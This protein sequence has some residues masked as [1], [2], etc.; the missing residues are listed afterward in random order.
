MN[1]IAFLLFLQLGAQATPAPV[2]EVPKLYTSFWNSDSN[3]QYNNNCYNYSTNRVTNSFAQPGEASGKMYQDIT[4]KDVYEAASQDLGLEPTEYFPYTDKKDD[5]LIAVVVAP[6]YDYHWYRRDD[7]GQWSHKPGGTP[8]TEFDN[9][10][11]II[12]DP[13]TADRGPYKEFCGY[14]RIKNIKGHDHEQDGGQVRV[15]NMESLPEK[16]K[17]TVEILKYSGR[18]NPT[19]DLEE[20]LKDPKFVE[21]LRG[22]KD[23]MVPLAQAT[24]KQLRDMSKLGDR[25][26]LIR[27][28]EGKVFRKGST[29]QITGGQ[30]VLMPPSGL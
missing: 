1:T 9:S 26:F 29:V 28:V 21:M 23:G 7:N 25:G 5:T 17:S 19:I 16:K 14:F 15:G 6:G 24:A 18:P 11:S 4:C 20:M 27:D 2:A 3:I 12:G 8:A 13:R 10:D 22:S 30:A